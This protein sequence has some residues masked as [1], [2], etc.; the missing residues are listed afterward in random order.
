MPNFGNCHVL[1]DR[2]YS[3]TDLGSFIG[4]APG[5]TVSI[6]VTHVHIGASSD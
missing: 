6:S 4:T 1:I 5:A 3:V 2:H